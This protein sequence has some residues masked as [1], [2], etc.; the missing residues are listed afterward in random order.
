AQTRRAHKIWLPYHGGAQGL[1]TG[2]TVNDLLGV[3][4]DPNVFIQES[5]VTT[6]DVRHGRRPRG[7]ALLDSLD[8]Y[9]RRAGLTV[10]TGTR[11]A[12]VGE[13]AG[14]A[15]VEKAEDGR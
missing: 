1:V 9:G 2:D 3:S 15:H 13:G 14:V 12:T 7:P 4:L 6:C 11:V 5:K 8:G 10:E